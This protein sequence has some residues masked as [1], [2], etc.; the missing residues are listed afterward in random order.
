MLKKINILFVC[1]GNICRSSAAEYIMKDLVSKDGLSDYFHIESKGTSS[2][3]EGNGMYPPMKRLLD[4][5]GINSSFHRAR[6]ISYKDYDNFDLIL[7][8]DRYNINN[9]NRIFDDKQSK[10]KLLPKY[11]G[12]NEIDDPWYTRDFDKAYQEI[13][14]SC[15]KLLKEIKE[16]Y[17]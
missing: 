7:G 4:S 11:A 6:Q 12:L 2:E 13:E 5:N 15:T 1:H 3:E 17:L 14:L 8:M 10:I 9:L 16:N